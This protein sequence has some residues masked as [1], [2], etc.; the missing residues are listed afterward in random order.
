MWYDVDDAN[1]FPLS[2]KNW[3]IEWYFRTDPE[4]VGIYR[5]LPIDDRNYVV[6]AEGSLMS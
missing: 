6:S 3:A 1:V 5:R 2:I 4:F